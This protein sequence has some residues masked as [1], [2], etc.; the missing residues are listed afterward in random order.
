MR[1]YA[2]LLGAWTD[3]TEK[4]TVE[5]HKD[6]VT[7]FKEM[8]KYEDY[9]FKGTQLVAECF[10]YDFINVQYKDINY[11]IHPSMIQI[12]NEL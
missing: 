8:L 2:N 4:G 7:Y 1:V 5:A 9:A 6:P 10:K 3:I 11:R 12:T